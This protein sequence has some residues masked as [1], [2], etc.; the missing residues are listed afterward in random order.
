MRWTM[1]AAAAWVVMQVIAARAAD[2]PQLG[3][4]P[5]R[6]N[7]T[8]DTVRPPFRLAWYRNFQPERV[9]RDVQAVVYAG[10]V[11]V[12]TKSGHLYALSATDG[13]QAWRFSCGGP[14]LHTAACGEGEVV[15]G[16]LD[17]VVYAV[18]ASTGALAWRFRGERDLGFSTA[19]LIAEDTVYIGAADGS[20]R[21]GSATARSA[22]ASRRARP[23][24]IPPPTTPARRSSAMK[25]SSCTA[26]TRQ[27]V[28]RSGEVRSSMG[29]AR[30]STTRS[31]PTGWC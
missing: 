5:Q 13:R 30:N 29:R 1:L 24:S 4:N 10:R 25:R 18:D 19:P 17:G 16:A 26:W 23:S 31:S 20:M 28:G 14:I 6:T 3:G 2:W 12:G 21:F 15:V 8:S 27:R 11:F 7:Y 9:S 22:G